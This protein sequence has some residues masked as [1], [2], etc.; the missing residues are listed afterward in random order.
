MAVTLAIVGT[1]YVIGVMIAIPVG[2]ISAL[3]QYS[4]FDNIAT[5]FAFI[6]FSIPTFFSGLLLIL[7]FSV[8]LGLLPFVYDTTVTGFWPRIKQSIMPVTVLALL[9]RGAVHPVRAGVD[10]GDDQPGLRADRPGEGAQGTDGWC[11]GTSCATR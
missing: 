10:A 1:A 11:S 2:V 7:L 8:Q 9:E 6:G 5:T 4:L 3:K